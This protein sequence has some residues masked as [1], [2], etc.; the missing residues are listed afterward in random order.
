MS[1]RTASTELGEASK[2]AKAAFDGIAFDNDE[3]LALFKKFMSHSEFVQNAPPDKIPKEDLIANEIIEYLKPYSTGGKL[4][5]RKVTYV[6]GRSNII[7]QYSASKPTKEVVSFVGSHMD[8]VSA[9]AEEWDKNPFELI[10]EGDTLYGRGTTDCLGHVCMITHL[11][12]KMAETNADTSVNVVAVFIANEEQSQVMGVGIDQLAEHGELDFLKNGPLYWVD[13]ADFGP[14]LATGGCLPWSLTATGKKFHSGFPHRAVNPITMAH[15]A[16]AYIQK[17]FY[18]DF[19]T[20]A[21]DKDYLFAVGSSM[22]PT[23]IK[24]PPGSLNQIPLTCTIEGDAR[25]TPF[26]AHDKVMA[27]VEGYVADINADPNSVLE[28]WGY[29]KY[30]V[31]DE[32][33]QGK[34]AFTWKVE[35]DPLLGVAVNKTSAGYAALEGAIAA[36]RGKSNPFSL[37]GSLPIIADLQKDGFDV[38]ICGFGNMATYHAINESARLSDLS[39]GFKVLAKVIG[40]FQ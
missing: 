27:A 5:V 8:C 40:H 20:S 26:T 25:L 39:D 21:K 10:V 18:Q 3:F 23:Q 34:I 19:G 29:E 35:G 24:C 11:F 15:Q 14:T 32:K 16:I 36:V 7:L 2:K 31:E 13:S 38:Q 30:T 28:T 9:T 12:K 17:R 4:S 1:K 6:E 37:T 22:K 33:V